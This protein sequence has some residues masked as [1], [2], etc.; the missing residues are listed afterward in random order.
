MVVTVASEISRTSSSGGGACL[1]V[2]VGRSS[3]LN[4]T[5]AYLR[6]VDYVTSGTCL[7]TTVS[8][9]PVTVANKFAG[10]NNG[11]SL[12]VKAIQDDLSALVEVN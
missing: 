9:V 11:A 10:K 4:V 8:G 3:A 6:Q 2:A 7:G 12:L 1:K 5:I